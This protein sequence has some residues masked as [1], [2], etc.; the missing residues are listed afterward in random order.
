MKI[1]SGISRK[2][3][4]K[5]TFMYGNPDPSCKETLLSLHVLKHITPEPILSFIGPVILVRPA[6]T[7]YWHTEFIKHTRGVSGGGALGASAPGH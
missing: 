1:L 4:K 2:K 7:K 6:C 3:K 5:S